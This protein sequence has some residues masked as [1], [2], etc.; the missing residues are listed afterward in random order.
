MRTV[1]EASQIFGTPPPGW[2]PPIGL[3][4]LG[5]YASWFP[6]LGALMATNHV[7]LISVDVN[8]PRASRNAKIA[9]ARRIVLPYLHR[10]G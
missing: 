7:D 10:S 3:N 2:A 8:W 1:V 5:P 4:G 6:E 9:L